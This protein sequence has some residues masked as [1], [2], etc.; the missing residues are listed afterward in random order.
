MKKQIAM[1]AACLGMLGI[2]LYVGFDT[3]NAPM[4]QQ[5]YNENSNALSA[6]YPTD[7]E[8]VENTDTLSRDT[9]ISGL[10]IKED[11]YFGEEY[12]VALY[13]R[14][15]GE[16]V[17]RVSRLQEKDDILQEVPVSLPGEVLEISGFFTSGES[18]TP[19]CDDGTTDCGDVSEVCAMGP[20]V[21]V[22]CSGGSA[23]EVRKFL[24]LW[25]GKTHAFDAEPV[26]IPADYV[27][28]S[29]T[30]RIFSR[31]RQKGPVSRQMLYQVDEQT[32]NIIEIRS[33]TLDREEE[34]L[35]IRDGL[36]Q[37]TLFSGNV[38]LDES[39]NLQNE[40]YFDCFFSAMSYVTKP[41]EPDPNIGYEEGIP[42]FA[43]EYDEYGLMDS[44]R[45]YYPDK[46]ALLS[47]QGFSGQEPFYQYTD[48]W[49]DL[50]VELY[51]NPATETG[52]GFYYDY[53]FHPEQEQIVTGYLFHGVGEHEWVQYQPYVLENRDGETGKE[54][55]D[56]GEVLSYEEE[57]RYRA[58]GKPEYF[59]A[60][61]LADFY[62]NGPEETIFLQID[63]VYRDDGC[64]ACRKYSHN[65]WMWGTSFSSGTYLYD[66]KE[67]LI[68][69]NLYVTHGGMSL[70]YIY[71]DDS[72][73]PAYALMLD[74][75]GSWGCGLFTVE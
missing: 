27:P 21:V 33:Y 3:Q 18:R 65:T 8:P 69:E 9:L 40:A 43:A 72:D 75:C 17:I 45:I 54:W 37:R 36:R 50:V 5:N 70:Y 67:R 29:I 58:D 66:E 35:E 68:Y 74:N 52:C 34:T 73:K 14:A 53:E 19:A 16:T 46:E 64:L 48:T 30:L 41:W 2:F 56:G 63:F 49:G 62:G 22:T 42:V 38:L 60:K 61:G 26:E 23:G 12:W 13:Q 71:E 25:E 39:G 31:T 47:E 32:K 44:H 51:F 4:A 11:W 1:C 59:C 6:S 24:Y 10:R 55:L 57:Y 20:D 28:E 15:S 7:E